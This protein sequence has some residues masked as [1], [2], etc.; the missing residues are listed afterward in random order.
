MGHGGSKVEY[1]KGAMEDSEQ[2][3]LKWTRVKPNSTRVQW[4]VRRIN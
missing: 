2:L 1:V 4:H 3:L